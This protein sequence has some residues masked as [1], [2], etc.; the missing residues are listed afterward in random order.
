[1]VCH[2]SNLITHKELEK[3]AC[4]NCVIGGEFNP[5][6]RKQMVLKRAKNLRKENGFVVSKQLLKEVPERNKQLLREMSH[7]NIQPPR[8]KSE[9]NKQL[10][11]EMSQRNKQPLREMSNR[12]KQLLG[13]M[14]ERTKQFLREMSDRSNCLVYVKVIALYL[15]RYLPCVCRG[16]FLVSVEVISF[17]QINKLR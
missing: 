6:K 3:K 4:A 9:R 13:E 16:N 10:L 2:Q 12:N 14:S 5:Y 8:E 7:R 17:Y 11:R 1:M 15:Q